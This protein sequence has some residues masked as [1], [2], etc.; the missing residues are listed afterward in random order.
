M[1]VKVLANLSKEATERF[2]IVLKTETPFPVIMGLAIAKDYD[3]YQ[4]P[5]NFHN[6]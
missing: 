3:Q 4:S 1:A 5:I 6:P 2:T